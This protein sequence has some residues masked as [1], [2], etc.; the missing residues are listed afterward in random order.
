[1]KTATPTQVPRFQVDD[2]AGYTYLE[3]N[4]YVVFK[5]VATPDE[6]EMGISLAWD[7]I[8]SLGI[9]VSRNDISTMNTDQWRSQLDPFGKGIVTANGVG[10]S[11][12]LW[13]AR[14]LPSVIKIFSQIWK[15]EDLITSF[16]GF[17]IHRAFEYNQAWKTLSEGWYHLDQNGHHKPSKMCI[18]GFLNFY[19]SGPDDGGLVVVPKSHTIFNEIFRSRPFLAKRD[20]FIVLAN[21]RDLWNKDL[22]RAGLAPIKVC[23]EP[24]DFVLWDSRTIHSNCSARTE[25]AIPKNAI[26]PP[27]RLVAYVCMTPASRLTPEITGERINCYKT[28]QTTSH[29]PEEAFTPAARKNYGNNYR[30]VVLTPEQKKLIPLE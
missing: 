20:D 24:G 1:L 18:Q 30:P 11:G 19:P 10:Q 22:P 26:L 15:T 8:E 13:F 16:D 9:G 5:N 2:P 14:G 12:F 29:W 3:E 21:D 23:C 27:R 25:R 4:G 6:I 17:C 28:G 7:F